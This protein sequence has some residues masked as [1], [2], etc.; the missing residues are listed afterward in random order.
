MCGL[1][2]ELSVGD[3]LVRDELL[4]IDELEVKD[5]VRGGVESKF[6]LLA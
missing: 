4:V 3:G 2:V 5:G 1:S 6:G